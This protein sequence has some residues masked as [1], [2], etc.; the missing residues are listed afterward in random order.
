MASGEGPASPSIRRHP[1]LWWRTGIVLAGAYG[2]TFSTS[3]LVYFTVQSNVIVLGYFAVTLH[4]MLRDGAVVTPAPRLRAAIT[5]WILITGL[6]AHVLLT[7]GANPLPGL[8]AGPDRYGEWATFAVHYVVPVMVL[9][10]WLAFVPR[11]Q[12]SWAVL[13]LW[14]SYPLTYALVAEARAAI[15]TGFDTPY[16]Y[17]FLDPTEHGYGWVGGQF[18]LLT[19]EFAVLGAILVLLDRLPGRVRS[20]G[21]AVPA[22][23][24][25]QREADLRTR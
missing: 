8:V 1:A 15:Y 12:V 18:L 10:D 14:L 13:P 23:R 2:L 17:Y 19:V 11:R 5:F 4:G 3:S 20:A 16:P 21:D 6:V 22:P 24:R 25:P 9:I 7:G